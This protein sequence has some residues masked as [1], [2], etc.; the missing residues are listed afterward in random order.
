MSDK[1]FLDT[2]V[3]VYSFDSRVPDKQNAA[4]QLILDALTHQNGCISYQVIQE[5]YNVA[6]RKFET[7]LSPGDCKIYLGDVLAPLCKIF[8][9]VE[10]YS[11]GLQ[12][13]DQW[14]YSFY[15]SLIITAALHAN[16]EI[17]Y[18]EDLQHGQV[19]NNL[20]IINPFLPVGS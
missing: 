7:P 14:K 6:T 3:I 12:V 15:D 10:F 11:H 19:I 5:F 16:C 4:R 17:L 20:K 13:A 2:N 1:F 8:P 18:S 9:S